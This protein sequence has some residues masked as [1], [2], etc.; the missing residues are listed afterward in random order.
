M[1][2]WARSWAAWASV[3][4][5]LAAAPA[6]AADPFLRRTATVE[7][8][9][10]VGPSVVNITTERLAARGRRPFGFGRRDP[11]SDFFRDFFE[12]RASR[13]EQSLGSGVIIDRDGHVITNEHVVARATRIRVTLADGR[14]FDASLVGADPNND[15]AVLKV[16][17][18]ESLPWVPPG[19]SKDILVGEPVIAIGNPFGLSNTVTTGV[20][21]A[22]NRSI[23]TAQQRV[24]HG[25]IQTDASINPGNSGGPLLN[26]E[27]TLVGINT[28]IYNGAEGIG[29]A[30]PID[31]AQRVIAELI[32][33]GEVHP[34]WLGLDFQDLDPGLQEVLE[35]PDDVFGALVNR[36]RKGG[37][38]DRGGLKRGDIVARVDGR[39]VRTA[40]EFFDMLKTVT[41]NQELQLEIWRDGQ[42]MPIQVRAEEVPD[43]II[44]ELTEQ[45]LGLRLEARERGG[46]VVRSVRSGSG[47]QRI[48]VKNGDLILGVNGRTLADGEALRR[49]VLD[50]R[51]REAALIVVQR[52]GGR[53]HVT[54]PLG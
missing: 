3:G 15:L 50:L 12:P 2:G 37:P 18:E 6:F 31:A 9:Q 7:V 11:F 32:E 44:P 22:T 19:T 33:F 30:I 40:R 38:A 53:Y 5:A 35:L 54:V 51:G 42:R 47:S 26:A 46:F 16:E 41:T 49:A 17:T 43:R 8:V 48:G 52:G 21:S 23:R 34:V 1:V 4:L 36:I 29:F 27:G 25:F 24:F 20:V 14:E 13:T 28:A 39:S 10:E 45:L